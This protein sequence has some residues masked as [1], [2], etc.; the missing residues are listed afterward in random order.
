MARIEED[1]E[2]EE[3]IRMEIAVD[4]CN[5]EEMA[6]GWYYYLEDKIR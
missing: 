5:E 4:A 6:M 3:R 1:K 2:R